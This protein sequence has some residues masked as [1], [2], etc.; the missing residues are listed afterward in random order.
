[1]C[2]NDSGDEK[3]DLHT[4][5]IHQ[6]THL[7]HNEHFGG[8]Y[9][10]TKA[11]A[12]QYDTTKM[13]DTR[14]RSDRR[15][16]CVCVYQWAL[17]LC[18]WCWWQNFEALRLSFAFCPCILAFWIE[19]CIGVSGESLLD[20]SLNWFGAHEIRFV[21]ISME[22]K[23]IFCQTVVPIELFPAVMH[24]T[25]LYT[26]VLMPLGTLLRVYILGSAQK[27]FDYFVVAEQNTHIGLC[28]L[29]FSI[30][31]DTEPKGARESKRNRFVCA[32]Q[33]SVCT[34]LNVC[35]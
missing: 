14:H 27:K 30:S 2:V 24:F 8:I 6:K 5:R 29:L 19:Y 13:L 11:L 21:C 20:S 4:R 33:Q 23:V 26:T 3:L 35:A 31:G 15:F 25:G 34:S 32:C 9:T 7:I 16:A 12:N 18:I 22:K 1:M 17:R 10:D 28:V